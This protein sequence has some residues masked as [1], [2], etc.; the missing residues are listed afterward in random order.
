MSPKTFRLKRHLKPI[1]DDLVVLS[2]NL[3]ALESCAK[4]KGQ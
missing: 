4:E 2:N 1:F 3:L